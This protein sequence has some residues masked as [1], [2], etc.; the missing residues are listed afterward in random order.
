MFE[1]SLK[2]AGIALVAVA[3]F[4]LGTTALTPAQA[5]DL[6]GDCCADL[7]ERVAELEATTVRKGNRKLSLTLSGHV[8]TGV[9][10]YDQ[11]LADGTGDSDIYV[12][13]NDNSMTRFR[14]RG[15]AKFKPGWEAGIY[16]ELGIRDGASSNLGPN[17]AD[18]STS[19]LI[20]HSNWYMKSPLGR[21]QVGQGSEAADGITEI[22]LSGSAII[23]YANGDSVL[24]PSNFGV[25]GYYSADG[26]RA[27]VVR[28]DTPTL[29]GF[30]LSASWGEDD[31]W[32]AAVRYAGEFNG[33]RVAAGAG[34]VWSNDEQGL[35]E[36]TFDEEKWGA[37]ASVWHVPTGIFV[38]AA[39]NQLLSQ[40]RVDPVELEEDIDSFYVK[41]G[42]RRRFVP[43]GQ[44]IIYGEYGESDYALVATA[45][46]DFLTASDSDFFGFGLV[47]RVSAAATELYIGYRQYSD[48]D[49]DELDVVAAGARIKF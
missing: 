48:S 16:I 29:A 44:T 5:A 21:I 10:Y 8:N 12:F 15:A 13:D 34:Y 43:L 40:D 31:R 11:S 41:A 33:L 23:G 28:Y 42:I 26:T 4:S 2:S 7:E 47:Q 20:R 27:N 17:D 45:G 46:D 3:G 18:N 24:D 38:T 39:Y 25:T 37:S 49:G 19:I 30:T 6:G 9:V 14:L 32:S 36:D 35:G 22:D 1:R